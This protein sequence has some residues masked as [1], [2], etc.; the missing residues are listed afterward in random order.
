MTRDPRS[1]AEKARAQ[2]ESTALLNDVRDGVNRALRVWNKVHEP[3]KS[4]LQAGQ[5]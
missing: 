2:A 3:S 1:D 4:A 5:W